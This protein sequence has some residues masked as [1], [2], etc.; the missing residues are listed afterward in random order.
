MSAVFSVSGTE[1]Q[2]LGPPASEDSA[3][4]LPDSAEV[5]GLFAS[6]AN[7][8]SD[9]HSP[10]VIGCLSVSVMRR[11]KELTVATEKENAL[12]INTAFPAL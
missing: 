2:D 11:P 5:S 3:Q 12:H 4:S 8:V 6:W 9:E 7:Q 1:W 10:G